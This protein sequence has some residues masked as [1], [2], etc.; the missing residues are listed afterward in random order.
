MSGFMKTDGVSFN[1]TSLVLFQEIQR[2][3]NQSIRH[4]PV[5]QLKA[6]SATLLVCG[7]LAIRF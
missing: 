3:F 1:T 2:I 6:Y 4:R 5:Y 7:W